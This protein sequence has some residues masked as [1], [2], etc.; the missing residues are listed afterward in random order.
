M[1]DPALEVRRLL[2]AAEDI[3]QADNQEIASKVNTKFGLHGRARMKAFTVRAH[4]AVLKRQLAIA[5]KLCRG[6]NARLARTSMKRWG[7][8][9]EENGS[10]H[11]AKRRLAVEA[12]LLKMAG[13]VEE[14]IQLLERF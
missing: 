8:A 7:K 6:G 4:K 3:D 12:A 1:K 9:V 11:K 13:G 10:L 5:K 2:L 14:A